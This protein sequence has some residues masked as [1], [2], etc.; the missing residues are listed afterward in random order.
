MRLLTAAV[1]SAGIA[2]AYDIPDNLKQIY[3]NHKSGK[4]QNKLASGFTDG[5][6]GSK[7]WAYC[8]D[9]DGAIFLHSSANGGEYDNMDVD[10]DGVNMHGGACGNDGTS[11][12]E[13]AFKDTV[14]K[15]GISDLNANIHPYVVFGNEEDKPSFDPQ[16]YGMDPL[17]VMA[18]VCGGQVYYGVW[19]DTNGGT[20][21]GEASI[22]LAQL[23]FPND[24]ISGDNGHDEED[25]LYIGFTNG[26]KAVPGSKADWK[27]KDTK[28]FEE[29]I[30]D[31][32]DSLVKGLKA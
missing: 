17:S 12:G 7:N 4:C 2:S 23:C 24:K 31:L 22:S 3:N 15:Y 11:Q 30:K 27:A 29:S 20:S 28:T 8:G 26:K 25:V 10:C 21:T 16:E 5:V 18:V 13:T 32:G 14:A 1:V 9:I 19:G 6:D